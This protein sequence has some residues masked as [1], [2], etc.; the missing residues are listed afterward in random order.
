MKNWRR[1]TG[2]VLLT[3]VLGTTGFGFAATPAIAQNA[4]QEQPA[5][6]KQL[7][8]KDRELVD[9]AARQG[10]PTV[11]LL[12]AAEE[13]RTDAAVN[14]LKALGATVQKTEKDVDYVKVTI[15]RDNAEKAAKLA[16]VTTIDVDGLIALDDPR[17]Q[18]MEN[19]APQKAPD[20][21]TPRTNPYMPTQDTQA[22]QFATAHPKWDGRGTTIAVIDSGIDLDTPAL[23]TTST[24]ERKII[25]WYNANATNSGDGTWVTMTKTG[26]VGK[27]T[28]SGREWTAPAT[29]GPY[30]FGLFRETAGDLN[31]AN[32]ETGGDI[33][34]DGDRVDTFGVIQD[35]TT[36]EVFVDTDGDGN[37]TN[38][39][40]MLDYK[41][42]QD[43]GFFGTDNPATPVIDRIAFVVQTD[44]SIY[45]NAGTPYVNLGI[46]AAHGTHVA[47]ITAAHKMFDGKMAGAAPG[48]KLMAIK[49]CLTT[50]SC[51]N[52]GLIDG[53][54]YA[55]RNGADVVN[56]SIGGLP[57]LN[58]G[59][60]A[61]AELYNRTIN[62]YNVQIFISAGNSGAGAN[63][64]GDPSVAT[65]AVSVGSYITKETW[66]SNYGSKT[67]QKQGLHG[68]SSRGPREDGG[69]KPNIVAPGS[70]ISTTPRWQPGGPVAGT[71]ALPA[72]YSQFNGTSMAAPQATGAAAL[73]V[74]AF[75]ATHN[76]QRP[77]S[78]ELR[79]AIQ[80]SAKWVD[81]LGAYEQGA[82]LFNT[83][84]A[85]SLLD[86]HSVPDQV[87]TAVQVSTVQSGQLATPNVGVGIH[88]REGV[89]AGQ[90][91]TRTYT[92]TRTTGHDQEDY[93]VSWK[94]NDGTFTAPKKVSLPLNT[95]V[96]FPVKVKAKTAGVHSAVLQLDNPETPGVDVQTL[97]TVFAAEN[98]TAANKF[99]VT[100]SGTIARNQSTSLFVNVPK[101][102]TALR[103]DMAAGGAEAGKGQVRF[104]RFTPQGVPLDV[105]SS[106]NCYNP[107]AGAGC[108]GGSP[109]SRTVANPIAGV[110][111]VVVEA[112][113]TSDADTAP[114]SV[115]ASVLGT[116]ISPTPDV[117]ASAALGTPVERGYTVTN[118][119]AAFTGRLAAGAV[120]SAKQDRPSIANLESKFFDIQVPAGASSITA[121]IGNTA[122]QGADLDLALL[123]CTTGT[124]FVATSSAD[125]DSEES[126][127]LTKPAA[128]LWRVQVEGY[129]VPQGTTAYDYFDVYTSAA[130]GTLTVSDANAARAAGA[131]WNATGVLTPLG[132]PG[133]GRVLRGDLEVRTADETAVGRGAVIVQSVG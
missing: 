57:S 22:A 64:V 94:G 105:T 6:D 51:T 17:P 1:R 106:T 87:T 121:T 45:D 132:Q 16:S 38:N 61:R 65:D 3:A 23:Q 92:L 90:E 117:I 59:N 100:K 73:L 60:N 108:A 7:D 67:A 32:S 52:S 33:N 70:A 72:G 102:T 42:K 28:D 41:V 96:L 131:T 107:D 114:Y 26:R 66:L 55:A 47:G 88:D 111:E 53:V 98:F 118:T 14:D 133:A 126:V 80:R 116:S 125:A 24:G 15:P 75:K 35:I 54:L 30:S 130:L 85:W 2:T 127:T 124:C 119:Q 18:G 79:Y 20:S 97:N 34:R 113:R 68:F 110:W 63:T 82:G 39:K 40:R 128:G 76:G 109:T 11:D 9:E 25:D 49:A 129:A 21:K 48:A 19:P 50:P 71:Y 91:Y 13:G 103:V 77:T 69:F 5:A 4:P 120:G 112:R 46:S 44:R 122:D 8:K 115:T 36:K 83:N 78:A 10:K 43:V 27:F 12:V 31:L 101:G 74:S 58:D 104:L 123:D 84:A 99:S 86:K 62:E 89:T 93:K 95:P 81:T 29:G 37:F 56:I